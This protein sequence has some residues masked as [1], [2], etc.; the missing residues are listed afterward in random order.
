MLLFKDTLFQLKFKY[1]LSYLIIPLSIILYLKYP[2]LKPV[3]IYHMICIGIIGTINTLYI[4]GKNGIAITFLSI[5][6]HLLLLF[7]LY[8]IK[9]FGKV[10]LFSLVILIF[11]NLLIY[12]LP[13]WPYY[14]SKNTVIIIYNICYLSLLIYNK[15]LF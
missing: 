7:V 15:L 11:A 3:L 9:K 13:Y 10:N 5:I 4:I 2:L 1:E 14:L 12:Y 6:L 8:D